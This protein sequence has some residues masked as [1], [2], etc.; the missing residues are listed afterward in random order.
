MS[1]QPRFSRFVALGDSTTEGLDDPYPGH[2]V[3]EEVFRGWADRLAERLAVDNDQLCYANLAIRGRLIGQIHETQLQPALEMQ[4]D[5]VSV[6]GG[7]NDVLRPKFDLETVTGHLETMVEAFRGR[8]ATVLVMTLPDL[9]TSMRVA[10]IVSERLAAFNQAIRDVAGR[11]GATLVDMAEELTV[12]D[13]RGWSPDRLHAND[14]GHQYLMWGAA[15]SLGLPG[16]ADELEALK[17]GVPERAECSA[18]REYG[19]EAAWVWQHLRPWIARRLKGTSSGDGVTPKR[20]EMIPLL[21][22]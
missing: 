8:S 7:V 1:D 11:T 2:P 14:I 15:K 10:R 18:L 5:I 22:G 12:Y 21:Q 4:P 17:A 16:A 19:A 20:P 13:P 6:V 3:G 9:G